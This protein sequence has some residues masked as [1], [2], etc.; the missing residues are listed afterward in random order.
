MTSPLRRC[1]KAYC[2]TNQKQ[3]LQIINQWSSKSNR[4][5]SLIQYIM[6]SKSLVVYSTDVPSTH[7][8]QKPSKFSQV[9]KKRKK[10]KKVLKIQP[11]HS[12]C[13][14]LKQKLL[15]SSN[16]WKR[17]ECTDK[18]RKLECIVQSTTSNKNLNQRFCKPG[19]NNFQR[20]LSYALL[21]K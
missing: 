11:S 19:K 1:C 6:T 17:K 18:E 3:T 2:T 16:E 20:S 14:A 10:L 4:S 15:L 5:L 8:A 7:Q 13:T 21:K 9:I 12:T